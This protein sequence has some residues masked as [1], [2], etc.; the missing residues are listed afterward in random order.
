MCVS[1]SMDVH[2]LIAYKKNNYHSIDHLRKKKL[3]VFYQKFVCF[4]GKCMDTDKIEKK[5]NEEEVFETLNY[6]C[7]CR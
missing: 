5:N 2:F 1:W 3:I 4:R 7:T 6:K